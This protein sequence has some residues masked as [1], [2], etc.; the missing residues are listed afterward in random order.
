[1]ISS[2]RI[3]IAFGLVVTLLA[4]KSYRQQEEEMPDSRTRGTIRISADES[5]RPIIDAQVAVFESNH[6]LANI[7]V[8]Y[9]PEADCLRDMLVDSVRMVIATRPN[10]EAEKNRVADTFRTELSSLVLAYD[11]IAVIGHPQNEDSFF[12]MTEIREVLTGRFKRNL[13]AVF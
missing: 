3:I 2:K 13:I 7:I 10:T 11:A 1:M 4:C 5:F 6:P 8:D 12:T 9:K